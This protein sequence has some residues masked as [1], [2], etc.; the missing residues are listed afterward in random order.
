M[1]LLSA[2]LVASVLVPATA[3]ADAPPLTA[4]FTAVDVTSA[5]HQWYATGTTSNTATIAT[6]GTVTFAYPTGTS[7]H[8]AAFTAAAKPTSCTP[9]L[10]ATFATPAAPARAPWTTSCR[11]DTP[12]TY[13]FVCQVHSAMR[14]TIV[15]APDSAGGSAG[16][17]VPAT[18]SLTLGG[19]ADLGHFQLAVAA[20]YTASMPATVTSSAGD[21]TLTVN[22][23]SPV[24]TGHLVNGTYVMAQPLQVKATDATHPATAFAP[25]ETPVTLLTWPGPIA[26]DSVTVG[27]KQSIAVTDPLR[28]GTYAKTLMFTLSTTSP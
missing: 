18:L 28:S 21:A 15:V 3:Q 7:I 10:G 12:G 8:D 1:N 14:A 26:S 4:G 19:S 24:A 17:T 20:D 6:G 25:V 22:D 27:F 2:A 23:P 5:N 16:G 13:A 9:P 11:F